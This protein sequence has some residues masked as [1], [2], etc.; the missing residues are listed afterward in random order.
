LFTI[1]SGLSLAPRLKSKKGWNEYR[2][3]GTD[4]YGFS[5]LP[6]GFRCMAPPGGFHSS[7]CW[8]GSFYNAGKHGYW[9]TAREYDAD[10]AYYRGITGGNALYE[11]G[12]FKSNAYS[13]RCV[14]DDY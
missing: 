1:D 10:L 3:N 6:G 5:A 14:N 7:G 11:K 13:V 2:G 9:W 12:Y 4:D 8:N